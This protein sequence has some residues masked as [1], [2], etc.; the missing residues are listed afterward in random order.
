[1]AEAQHWISKAWPILS[2]GSQDHG[3]HITM[4]VKIIKKSQHWI[5]NITTNSHHWMPRSLMTLSIGCQYLGSHME[6]NVK[7]ISYVSNG[8][9]D[10]GLSMTMDVKVKS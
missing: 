7:I 9:Y 5:L 8:I 2:I 6:L 4:N 1:M 10:H 3:S